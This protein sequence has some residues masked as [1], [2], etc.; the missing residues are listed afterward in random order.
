MQGAGIPGYDQELA[1]PRVKERGQLYKVLTALQ[2]EAEGA[3]SP[4]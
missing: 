2:Y 3:V 1:G 4:S